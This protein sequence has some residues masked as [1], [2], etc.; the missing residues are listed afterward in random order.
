MVK[1]AVLVKQTS[2]ALLARTVGDKM[3]PQ[4]LSALAVV[5]SGDGCL[6]KEALSLAQQ[7]SVDASP[8]GKETEKPRLLTRL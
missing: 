1:G 5:H 6:A 7:L 3:F 8:E 2:Q 4:K